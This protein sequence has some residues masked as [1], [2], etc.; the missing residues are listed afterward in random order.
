MEHS[1]S[2]GSPDYTRFALTLTC[3]ECCK[4]EGFGGDLLTGVR[5]AGESN[6]WF[7]GKRGGLYCRECFESLGLSWKTKKKSSTSSD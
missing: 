1:R 4:S 6:R 3:K 7:Y 5:K 2:S